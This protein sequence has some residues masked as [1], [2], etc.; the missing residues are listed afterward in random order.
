MSGRKIL[1]LWN[2]PEDDVYEAWRDEGPQ[3]LDWDP[4]RTAPI[5]ATVAEEIDA[6]VAAVH[7]GGH[8]VKSHNLRDDFRGLIATI[9]EYHPDAI[10]NLVDFFGDDLAYEAHVPGVYELLGIAYTGSRPSSLATCVRKHRTKALLEQAG[11]P[12]PPYAVVD[13]RV[14]E[15]PDHHGLTFPLIVKPALE[16]ASGGIDFDAV[17]FDQET[18]EA[19]V[20]HVLRE[21]EMPVL[22][23]E[24]I[25]GREIH[26]AILG[27]DPPHALPLFEMIFQPR[28]GADGQPLPRIVTFRAKWDPRSKDFFDVDSRCPPDD[29]EPEIVLGIQDVAVRA[30]RV[31]G[32]RDYA[33]VDMRLDPVSGEPYI[34]EI[35]PNPD[36]AEHGA[37]M[38]CALASGRS[39]T[40]TVN[41]IVAM[42]LARADA[43]AP[44]PA[45]DQLLAEHRR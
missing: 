2:Q 3:A 26:C 10:V 14:P 9:D 35:N 1:I 17:V 30:A 19:R 32:V 41:E 18:L 20:A 45:G 38:A 34:L 16:D 13:P 28:N 39:F 6:I 8:Q 36:L 42:A 15:R 11:L 21:H 33:R 4:S 29:L 44:R 22:I 37:F 27:N 23:E 43:A 5:V 40:Q 7:A 24:Y 12:T 31:V 25:D